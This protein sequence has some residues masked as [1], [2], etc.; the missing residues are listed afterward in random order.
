ME[1]AFSRTHNGPNRSSP[2][3]LGQHSLFKKCVLGNCVMLQ[4][5]QPK[6]PHVSISTT[7]SI[8]PGNRSWQCVVV[9]LSTPLLQHIQKSQWILGNVRAPHV[10][11][12]APKGEKC[13]IFHV[14]TQQ[15]L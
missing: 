11:A 3:P 1:E 14:T 7:K 6:D 5:E 8:S 9:S 13:R 15:P 12:I 2:Q 10:K 4:H